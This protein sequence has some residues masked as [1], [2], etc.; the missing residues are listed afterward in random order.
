MLDLENADA[1][2]FMV[3]T[4]GKVWLNVDGKCVVRIGHAFVVETDDP[5]YGRDVIYSEFK[6]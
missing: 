5:V 2:E 4:T 6:E 1:V 3:D